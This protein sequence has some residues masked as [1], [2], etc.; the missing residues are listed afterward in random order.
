MTSALIN[1]GIVNIG[2]LNE[3]FIALKQ[4]YIVVSLYGCL[5]CIVASCSGIFHRH[6]QDRYMCTCAKKYNL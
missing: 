4:T 6:M 3:Q 2:F 1:P 5:T